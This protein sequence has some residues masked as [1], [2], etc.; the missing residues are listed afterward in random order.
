MNKPWAGRQIVH[1]ADQPIPLYD[2]S[3]PVEHVI[4]IA[5]SGNSGTIYFGDDGVDSKSGFEAGLPLTINKIVNL[6][7][8]DL[9]QCYISGTTVDDAVLIFAVIKNN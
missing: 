5:D 8:V 4:V 6:W 1:T 7:N 3:F 9:S 2:G